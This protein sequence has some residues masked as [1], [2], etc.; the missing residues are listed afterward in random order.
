MLTVKNVHAAC[1]RVQII[2]VKSRILAFYEHV[3]TQRELD[4]WHIRK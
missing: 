3:I 4:V 2:A 1:T